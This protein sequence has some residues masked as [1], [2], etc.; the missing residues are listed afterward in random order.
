[1]SEARCWH[2]PLRKTLAGDKFSQTGRMETSKGGTMGQTCS[3]TQRL[4]FRNKME[5]STA[6]QISQKGTS[7]GGG[8]FRQT[9]GW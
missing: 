7:K 6:S 9:I 5:G 8:N 2:T 3:G 1:M 4:V